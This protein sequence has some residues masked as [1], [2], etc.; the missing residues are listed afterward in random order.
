MRSIKVRR[1]AT[2]GVVGAALVAT[3]LVA[4][5]QAAVAK[6]SSKPACT[7]TTDDGH[8]P[9][10]VQGRPAGIDPKTTNATYMWHDGSG[11]HIR[12]THRHTN[13]RTFSGQITTGGIFTGAKPVHLE[14]NDSFSVSSDKHVISFAFKNYGF[15]DGLNFY[16]RCAP[17]ITFSFQSD[18]KPS[19]P[20]NV[21]IG[22]KSTRPQMNPFIISRVVPP[23]TTTSVSTAPSV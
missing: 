17:S 15:I 11:W 7:V 18:G 8:W 6:S 5:S 2:I 20:H 4:L 21:V 19:P 14:K 1:V 12:V 9:G 3:S 10:F 16:T 13:L 22:R 23:A